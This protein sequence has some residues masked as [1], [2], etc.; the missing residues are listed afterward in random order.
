MNP[1]ILLHFPCCESHNL[2]LKM[3]TKPESARNYNKNDNMAC[4]S[5]SSI[6]QTKKIVIS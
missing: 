1:I 4:I 6:Y 3:S 5:A 2:K